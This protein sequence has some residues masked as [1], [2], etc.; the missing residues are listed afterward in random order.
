[1][2]NVVRTL[3]LATVVALSA[4]APARAATE[5]QTQYI[6]FDQCLRVIR[7]IAARLGMAP[8]NIVE[9]NVLRMVRF[10][11]SDGSVLVTCS[12]PDRKMVITHIKN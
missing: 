10:V 7:D 9:T 5:T 3:L 12:R 1:M 2:Q 4:L 6:G 8:I 11:T